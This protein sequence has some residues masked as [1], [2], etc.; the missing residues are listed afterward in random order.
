MILLAVLGTIPVFL[1]PEILSATTVSGTMVI[2]LTPVFLFWRIKA[3]TISFFLSVLTGIG[4]GIL[5]VTGWHPESI[6]LTTGKYA[7]LLWLNVWGV[8]ACILLFFI[9]K[10]WKEL[11]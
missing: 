4:F 3:P 6:I 1:D 5:L 10:W 2:G 9:P 7:E 8:L 11:R